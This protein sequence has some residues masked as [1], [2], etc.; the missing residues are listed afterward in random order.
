[1]GPRDAAPTDALLPI[2]V[3]PIPPSACGMSFTLE[4]ISAAMP[5]TYLVPMPDGMVADPSKANVVYEAGDG[6][7]FL[8][9]ANS[10][11]TC[12]MGWRFLDAPTQIEICGI[13]CDVIRNDPGAELAILFGCTGPPVPV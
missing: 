13:P 11:A 5:C 2:D 6:G 10:S 8:V 1:V 12:D 7:T 3:S 4:P 9:M